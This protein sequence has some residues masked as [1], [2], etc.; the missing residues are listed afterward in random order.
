MKL[1]YNYIIYKYFIFFWFQNRTS[2]VTKENAIA[3]VFGKIFVLQEFDAGKR[4]STSAI[5]N[6]DSSMLVFTCRA[7]VVTRY[8]KFFNISKH[9]ICKN[10]LLIFVKNKKLLYIFHKLSDE[11]KKKKKLFISFRIFALTSIIIISFYTTRKIIIV[12][13]YNSLLYYNIRYNTIFYNNK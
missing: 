8:E 3:N 1:F 5:F 13:F 2:I 7:C 6:T 10:K 4:T 9:A 12:F 11:T